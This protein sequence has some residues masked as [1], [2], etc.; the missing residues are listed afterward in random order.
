MALAKI[1]F[2]PFGYL[3]DKW[4]WDVFSGNIPEK[5]WN[6]AW[7]KY[8]YELQGIKPPVQRSEDD[9]DPASKYHIPANVPYI[10]YFVSFVVQF[11]FHKALCIK[12][13]Q[14]DP[15]DPNK[16]FH[17]CDIYQSTEAGKA[18]KDML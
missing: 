15:S 10:R 2:L 8:R 7:W 18:L 4:R 12:A 14:Y 13:G 16:P 6:C 1:V 3:M 11:Q 17:K 5:D 9:F